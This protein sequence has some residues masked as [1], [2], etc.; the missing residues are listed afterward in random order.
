M[1]SGIGA[2]IWLHATEV[3]VIHDALGAERRRSTSVAG[4]ARRRDHCAYTS[5]V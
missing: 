4:P 2:A 3:Q 5:T 1:D